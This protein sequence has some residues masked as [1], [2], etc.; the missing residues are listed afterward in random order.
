[1][2]V[3]FLDV[4]GVLN[5][6]SLLTVVA[7]TFALCPIACARLKTL[8]ART[9]ARIVLSSSWRIS[10]PHV[11]FLH[12]HGV[13]DEAHEDWHTKELPGDPE[14]GYEILEWLSRHPEVTRYAIV[15]DNDDILPGQ[16]RYFIRTSFE[17]GLLD[18]HV[19]RLAAILGD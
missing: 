10:E 18:K 15:D 8:I 7:E 13:L 1:M 16:R 2:K 19:N 17:H 4:D 5:R 11:A 3:L 14:R 9:G 6:Q 12:K